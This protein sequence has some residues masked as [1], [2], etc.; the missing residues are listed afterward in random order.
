MT[1]ILDRSVSVEGGSLEHRA[2]LVEL[3]LIAGC[4]AP[5]LISVPGQTPLRFLS[6]LLWL[7]ILYHYRTSM[8]LEAQRLG[9]IFLLPAVLSLTLLWTTDLPAGI[10]TVGLMGFG[11][12]T[13]FA[14]VSRAGLPSMN[15]HQYI[16]L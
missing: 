10:R 1:A 11:F 15:D 13:V 12:I 7:P 4:F 5:L 3:A 14:V 8:F 16:W 9:I 2:T 6:L